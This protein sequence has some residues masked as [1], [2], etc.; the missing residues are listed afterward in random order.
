MRQFVEN[1]IYIARSADKQKLYN[2]FNQAESEEIE[3]ETVEQSKQVLHFFLNQ[4]NIL[5]NLIFFGTRIS[6]QR[7]HW[8]SYTTLEGIGC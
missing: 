1:M 6:L 5:I 2:M 4:N 3:I 8:S 7:S